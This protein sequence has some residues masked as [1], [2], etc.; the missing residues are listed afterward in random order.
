MIATHH[1][2]MQ[3]SVS[4]AFRLEQ[5][6]TWRFNASH[7]QRSGIALSHDRRALVYQVALD[8]RPLW[9]L[10]SVEEFEQCYVDLLETHFHVYDHGHVL[11]QDVSESNVMARREA[12]G[13]V[14]GLL[15]DWD[16]S[17]FLDEADGSTSSIPHLRTGTTPFMAIDLQRAASRDRVAPDHRYCHDLESFFWLLLWAVLHLDL[18]RKRHR[19]YTHEDWIGCC[20][21]CS[22]RF[23]R[24]FMSYGGTWDRVL[25]D[26]L[27]MWQPVLKRWV[28]P[29]A[30]M[31]Y[32]ARE[33]STHWNDD[34]LR[35]FDDDVYAKELTF[36]VFMQTIKQIPSKR[37][38]EEK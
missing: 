2:G 19:N 21:A 38:Q 9:T 4:T 8:F 22:L 33:R 7:A 14:Y 36:D 24:D 29:L 11:H 16:I 37:M 30:R 3:S 35:V 13:K 32:T 27:H 20:Q 12:D 23:K 15:I 17:C 1:E 25:D 31:I 28:K 10:E 34:N 5:P 6:D 18:K 26:V